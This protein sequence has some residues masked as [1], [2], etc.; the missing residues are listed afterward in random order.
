MDTKWAYLC[1][2]A[3]WYDPVMKAINAFNDQVNEK[4]TGEVTVKLYKGSA[5]PVA[6]KSKYGLDHT[7]F[8][9]AEGYGFNVNASAG[10]TEIYT[11]QM[12][13]ANQKK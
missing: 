1:Y 11:L 13:L 3:M 5:K 12:K 6:M 4:V 8:N 10:F 7:S 9:N 2:A